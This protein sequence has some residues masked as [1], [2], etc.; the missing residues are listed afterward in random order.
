MWKRN[1]AQR[2]EVNISSEPK[3]MSE[4]PSTHMIDW[5]NL[6]ELSEGWKLPTHLDL[7]KGD[8]RPVDDFTHIPQE[9]LITQ[10]LA[11]I[12]HYRHPDGRYCIGQ[13]SA[14]YWMLA[15]PQLKGAIA[16]DWFYVPDVPA[17]PEGEY[18]RSYVMWQEKKS[19]LLALEF[20]SESGA[21]ERDDTPMIGQYW[22]C[23]Q[24]IQSTYYG[25]F[26]SKTRSLNLYR[27][28][29]GKYHRVSENERGHCCIPELGIELGIWEGEFH[30]LLIP[31]L[32]LWDLEGNLLL[33]DEER[34]HRQQQLTEKER[35]RAEEERRRAEE[36]RR[37]AEEERARAE[38]EKQRG[39]GERQRAEEERQRAEKERQRAELE[40]AKAQMLAAQLRAWGIHPGTF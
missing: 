15:S 23:E 31:W 12:L 7:P 26:A 3:L 6:G 38:Q 40:R 22:I 16:V 36:E 20:V 18:R 10:S 37:R 28:E 33:H 25:I 5:N 21:A 30:N 39:D 34:L 35:Q 17:M 9:Q 11:P 27:L 19:P 1:F 29:N 14:I 4:I 2:N 13:H 24:A 8:E 32:R